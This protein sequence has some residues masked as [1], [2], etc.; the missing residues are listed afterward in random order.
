MR[1]AIVAIGYTL[2][3]PAIRTRRVAVSHTRIITALGGEVQLPRDRI[4]RTFVDEPVVARHP[5]GEQ[6]SG[7]VVFSAA[8]VQIA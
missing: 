4:R 7:A 8:A 2:F 3:G 5:I 1:G 6:P